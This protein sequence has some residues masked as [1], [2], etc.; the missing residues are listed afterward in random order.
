MKHPFFFLPALRKSAGFTLIEL[1]I[2]VAI[3]GILAAVAVPAYTDYVTRGKIPE[4][5]SALASMRIRLEQF[6]QD[7]RNYGSDD[8]SCGVPNPTSDNFTYRCDWT[9]GGGVGGT[10]QFYLITATGIAG[11]GMTGFAYTLDQAGN[12]RTTNVPTAAWGTAP[13]ACWVV[14][15]GGGC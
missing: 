2:T 13:L 6:Y 8:D 14:K 15:K 4:A 11:R 3:I 9:V 1:M 7:N 10:N 12:R 5:T